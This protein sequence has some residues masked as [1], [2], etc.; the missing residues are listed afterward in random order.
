[1]ANWSAKEFR[2][3]EEHIK[4]LQ[5]ASICWDDSGDGAPAIDC[6]R[7]YGNSHYESDVVEIC[8]WP[9]IDYEK[10]AEAGYRQ[11]QEARSLH[12]ETEMALRIVLRYIGRDLPPGLYR[13][14]C[15]Y[16]GEWVRV[17]D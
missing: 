13:T 17:S 1:M 14:E 6:K 8:G 7:P 11:E 9:A 15:M 12:A 3:K 5:R 10:D 4:L 2:L 16:S